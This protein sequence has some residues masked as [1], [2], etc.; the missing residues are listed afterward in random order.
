MRVGTC[1]LRSPPP[2]CGT[3]TIA[4]VA[5]TFGFA[6]ETAAIWTSVFSDTD[7]AV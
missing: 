1:I 6:T 4:A 5:E 7:G 3:R 2:P